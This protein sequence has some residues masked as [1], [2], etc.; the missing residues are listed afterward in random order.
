[1]PLDFASDIHNGLLDIS[2]LPDVAFSTDRSVLRQYAECGRSIVWRRGQPEDI[3]AYVRELCTDPRH[4]ELINAL[5]GAQF[6]ATVKQDQVV[7]APFRKDAQRLENVGIES[8][9]R[10][11]DIF[12][13]PRAGPFFERL[14]DSI[15]NDATHLFGGREFVVL[16]WTLQKRGP[17]HMDKY[18]VIGLPFGPD[19]SSCTQAGAATSFEMNPAGVNGMHYKLIEGE[20]VFNARPGDLCLLKLPHQEYSTWTQEELT[21]NPQFKVWAGLSKMPAL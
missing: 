21:R 8:P 1:M 11:S 2:G 17:F 7:I 14:E 4:R 16:F 12:V 5:Q 10:F 13:G 20:P 18:P 15:S 19:V 6:K 3:A 9:S